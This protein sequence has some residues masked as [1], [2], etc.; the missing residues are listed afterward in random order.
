MR[1]STN[2]L[3]KEAA[4]TDIA[5]V[6]AL[7]S[8][9]KSVAP[10][11][12]PLELKALISP[13]RKHGRFTLRIENLP[14]SARLSAGQ[15]NGDHTWSLALDELD[16]LLYFPPA[17]VDK[18][19]AIAIRVITRDET[20]ASTIALIDHRIIC[21]SDDEHVV[22]SLPHRVARNSEPIEIRQD[23][24]L[25]KEISLLKG[26]LAER[27]LELHR[28]RTSNEQSNAH[29][30]DRLN[31]LLAEAESVWRHDEAF[32]LNALE[33]ALQ[34][35][36]ERKLAEVRLSARA[37]ADN[38]N[39][40]K[41]VALRNA[42]LELA[43]IKNTLGNREAEL[44]K[45]QSQFERL[46]QG[47]QAD[48]LAAKADAQ[49]NVAAAVERCCQAERALAEVSVRCELAE[50]AL[51]S[52]RAASA[53]ANYEGELNQLRLELE[54]RRQEAE[55]QRSVEMAAVDAKAAERLK[56]AQ[57]Q[58]EQVAAK[59][60]AEITAR[61]ESAEA[62]LAATRASAATDVDNELH[63]LRSE[64]EN[65]RKEMEADIAAVRAAAESRLAERLQ[66]AEAQW[67]QS[68]EKELADIT[69]RCESAE[70]AV[71][72][73]RGNT[74]SAEADEYVRSLIREIKT[75]QATLVDRE[76]ALAQ[77][78]A[79]LEQMRFGSVRAIS[80]LPPLSHPRRG[81]SGATNQPESDKENNHLVRDV[82]IVFVVV[83]AAVLL[84]PQ[85]EPVSPSEQSWHIDTAGGP[86]NGPP[87]PSA[88]A[89][90]T[91]S[92]TKYPVATILREV[93]LRSL[94]SVSAGVLTSLKSGT[95]IAVLEN[96]GNWDR[97]QISD[98]G[99]IVQQ[100]WVYRSFLAEAGK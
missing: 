81:L 96:R 7:A 66:A 13:Y 67:R 23:D 86:S 68:A 78:H 3:R 73:A 12:V 71:M 33:A 42:Q 45:L 56:A 91:L 51:A 19:H 38:S 9:K 99:G 20:G 50:A 37:D 80:S 59:E 22:P 41:A 47:S 72:A 26:T 25:R 62:A 48:V 93:N 6:Y 30:T 54:S 77:V 88:S 39:K 79:S 74:Q 32:R 60:L 10:R 43:T 57:A 64:V 2:G 85:F 63:Q 89:P 69:A 58:W 24:A 75:L 4:I 1:R 82:F 21:P 53:G 35:Q 40:E 34:D 95:Q 94:P 87:K 61:C 44:T 65:R 18:E 97:I 76:A 52:A 98:E 49:A 15:N 17:G 36:F 46:R 92:T 5:E 84:F 14:Q 27:D 16:D 8:A 70:A 100:G 28:L 90:H 55:S 83:M 11:A 29:L 31:A